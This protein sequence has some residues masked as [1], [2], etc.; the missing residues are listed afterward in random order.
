MS[1]VKVAVTAVGAAAV[2]WVLWYFL[3]PPK[4]ASQP[5]GALHDGTRDVDI[6]VKAGYTPATISA[7]AGERLRL[8]FY[9]DETDACSDRVIFE[10]GLEVNSPLPAFQTTTLEVGP[11]NEG[12]YPFHCGMNMLKGRIVVAA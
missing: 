8:N 4:A 10:N 12:E 6:L 9:R 5:T 3:S 2:A 11:L 1:P 7:R